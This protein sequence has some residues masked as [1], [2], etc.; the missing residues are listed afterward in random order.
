MAKTTTPQDTSPPDPDPKNPDFQTVLKSLLDIYRPILEEDL[1]RASDPSALGN[2]ALKAPPT[3][4][5]AINALGRF[6]RASHAPATAPQTA[7]RSSD[8]TTSARTPS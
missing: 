8:S 6:P 4:M 3:I 1:K 2:E 7:G 5:T